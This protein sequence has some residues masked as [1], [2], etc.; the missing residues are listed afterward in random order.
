[1]LLCTV[2][3]LIIIITTEELRNERVGQ[4]AASQ[5]SN[6]LGHWVQAEGSTK[7]DQFFVET[8]EGQEIY[9]KVFVRKNRNAEAI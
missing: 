3:S 8:I 5:F 9:W 6:N 7:S 1:M 2:Y 4:V